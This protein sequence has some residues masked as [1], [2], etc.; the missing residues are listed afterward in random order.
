MSSRWSAWWSGPLP[1]G[2]IAALRTLVYLY[3]PADVFWFT[4]WVSSHRHVPG[5]LYQPLLVGRL[6]PLPVPG[7]GWVPVLQWALVLAAVAAATGRAPRLLGTVVFLLYA[8]WMVVAFSYGK[9]D[10]DRFAFL[11]ALAVLPT[12][13]AAV[14]GDRRG[15][16][17]AGWALRCVQVAVVL[18]YFLSAYAK[19]RF[20]GPDWVNGSTLV[21]AVLR[22]GTPLSEPL[23][24]V[25]WLL[26]AAQY[27]AMALELLSPLLLVVRRRWQLLGVAGLYAFHLLTFAAITILFVPHL[28]AL[29]A[30]LPLERLGQLWTRAPSAARRA[31]L[32]R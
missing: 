18:T 24:S 19:F 14:W 10:H 29:A 6:L 28:V 25:P 26:V 7:P 11:V 3:V 1:L 21:R 16:E 5:E 32:R 13:G 31:E 12:V 30:F 9:V 23:L 4:S 2:R 27:A 17:A 15:S 22:R 20:A 8:E